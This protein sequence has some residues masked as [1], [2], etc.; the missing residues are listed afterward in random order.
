MHALRLPPRMMRTSVASTSSRTMKLLVCSVVMRRLTAGLTNSVTGTLEKL[1]LMGRLQ[2]AKMGTLP[3]HWTMARGCRRRKGGRTP[4]SHTALDICDGM[5]TRT[6]WTHIAT[7]VLPS[8]T[9]CCGRLLAQV[10]A[11]RGARWGTNCCFCL[12]V[13]GHVPL[14]WGCGL[15]GILCQTKRMPPGRGRELMGEPTLTWRCCTLHLP[16]FAPSASTMLMASPSGS[17]DS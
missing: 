10:V 13:R 17:H 3:Q 8:L 11:L 4:C 14:T 12:H 15:R 9:R 2:H 6:N 5:R 7:D 16:N 1:V